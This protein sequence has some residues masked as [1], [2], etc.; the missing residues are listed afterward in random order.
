MQATNLV[1]GQVHVPMVEQVNVPIVEQAVA[2][3]VDRVVALTKAT[4]LVARSSENRFA[5][6]TDTSSNEFMHT[7]PIASEPVLEDSCEHPLTD[8]GEVDE[9][10]FNDAQLGMQIGRSNDVDDV[11]EDTLNSTSCPGHNVQPKFCWGDLENEKPIGHS[12]YVRSESNSVSSWY[13][14]G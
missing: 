5:L 13:D 4:P 10:T 3:A 11:V 1:V 14:E 7:H 2:S 12:L 6:L 9:S 8:Q